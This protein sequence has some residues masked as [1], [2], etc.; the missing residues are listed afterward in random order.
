V[1]PQVGLY[2]CFSPVVRRRERNLFKK[3]ERQTSSNDNINVNDDKFLIR[4]TKRPLRHYLDHGRL[5]LRLSLR[6]RKL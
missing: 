6:K 1:P 3:T 4:L 5:R 2:S